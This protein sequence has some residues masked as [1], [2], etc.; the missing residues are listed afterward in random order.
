MRFYRSAPNPRAELYIRFR[1]AVNYFPAQVRRRLADGPGM[2]PHT[3]R[4]LTIDALAAAVCLCLRVRARR[5]RP[6][7]LLALA[8]AAGAS[9]VRQVTA[10]THSVKSRNKTL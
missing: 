6:L 3:T 2:P 7:P 10:E 1:R 8:P 5:G 4:A 9:D